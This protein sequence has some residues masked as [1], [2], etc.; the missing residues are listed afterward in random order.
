ME[1]KYYGLINVE[2][3]VVVLVSEAVLTVSRGR[4]ISISALYT[5]DIGV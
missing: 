1:L 4:T 5:A 3:S 2:T